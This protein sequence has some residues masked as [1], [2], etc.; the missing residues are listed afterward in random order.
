MRRREHLDIADEIVAEPLPEHLFEEEQQHAPNII[1]VHE[2]VNDVPRPARAG[3]HIRCW[4]YI[5]GENGG[6]VFLQRASLTDDPG[7]DG[8]R[9]RQRPHQV[10][11]EVTRPTGGNWL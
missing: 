4:L 9:D 1:A 2:F 8:G 6:R 3:L 10:A 7:E 5:A 11:Q